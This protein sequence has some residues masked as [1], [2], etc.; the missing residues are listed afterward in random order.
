MSVQTGLGRH[1][2]DH[3]KQIWSDIERTNSSKIA[4]GKQRRLAQTDDTT[5]HNEGYE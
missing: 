1:C 3:L 2:R 5:S 4:E